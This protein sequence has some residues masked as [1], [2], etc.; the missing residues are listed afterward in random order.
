[1]EHFVMFSF[2]MWVLDIPDL[3]LNCL[4]LSQNTKFQTYLFIFKDKQ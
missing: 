3:Y 2:G 4:L 1:M